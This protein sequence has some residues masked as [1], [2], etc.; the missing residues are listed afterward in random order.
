M[1]L[2]HGQARAKSRRT[3]SRASHA[4]SVLVPVSVECFKTSTSNM[5]LLGVKQGRLLAS[6]TM[7]STSTAFTVCATAVGISQASDLCPEL[8]NPYQEALDMGVFASFDS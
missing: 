1:A 6:T 4:T 8:F 3:T 2:C 5:P 7:R